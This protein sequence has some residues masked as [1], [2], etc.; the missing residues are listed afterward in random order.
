MSGGMLNI[1]GEN[2]G[3]AFYRYEKRKLGSS[4]TPSHSPPRPDV[5]ASLASFFRYKMPKLVAKVEGRGNGIKTNIVNNVDIAKALERPPEYVIKYFGIELGA[6]TKFD[7]KSGT[8]IVNGA[9]DQKKLSE[10]LELFI[11]K[12]VQCY[13]CGNPE[14]VVKIK[15]EN[16]HLKCKACGFVST[17]DPLLKLNTFIIKNPPEKKLSKAEKKVK[18]AEKERLKGLAGEEGLVEK[19]KKEKKSKSK[20]KEKKSKKKDKEEEA[21][22]EGKVEGSEAGMSVSNAVEESEEEEEEEEGVVWMTDTSDAAMKKRAE[23]QLSGATAKLVT[24]GNAE[25]EEKAR[26]KREKEER[27]EEKEQHRIAS[28]GRQ[29]SNM[30]LD[31]KDE[32]ASGD[33]VAKLGAALER[34]DMNEMKGCFADLPGS[35]PAKM[36]IMYGCL[37]GDN[38]DGSSLIKAFQK[39]ER[40]LHEL[41]GDPASQLAQMMALE[42]L[43]ASSPASG[44]SRK[45]VPL[46][47]K[48]LYEEDIIDEAIIIGWHH[49]ANASSVLGVDEAAA[50]EIRKS[51]EPVVAWLEEASTDEDDSEYSSGKNDSLAPAGETSEIETI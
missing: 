47:L 48:F 31:S 18:A 46:V 42:A 41:A 23:E 7:K 17:V 33:L 27:E 37:F 51:A 50:E 13:G 44:K 16:I 11:K 9:H 6:Q 43:L 19:E 1:G 5:L 49:K 15:K 10:V 39:H 12:Y 29:T 40:V 24:Q 2:A 36:Q 35:V 3:D 25:A 14:T 45:E 20:D 30:S 32:D 26:R 4:R 21:E 28:L 38:A 8:S 22:S 34:G